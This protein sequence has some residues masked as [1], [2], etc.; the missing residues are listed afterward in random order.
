[1]HSISAGIRIAAPDGSS[2]FTINELSPDDCI[3]NDTF[4]YSQGSSGRPARPKPLDYLVSSL[5]LK[6]AI[7]A[8]RLA[9]DKIATGACGS[10][11]NRGDGFMKKGGARSAKVFE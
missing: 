6:Q 5:A 11:G 3:G 2:C 10:L 7:R 1:M 8:L 9:A 4:F